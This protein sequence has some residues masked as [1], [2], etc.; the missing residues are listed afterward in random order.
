MNAIYLC[1]IAKPWIDVIHKLEKFYGL[2][3]SYLVI[4]RDEKFEYKNSGFANSYLQTLEEAWKG[5][6]FPL[7]TRKK[8]LDE[9]ELN[10]IA[11][12]ELTALRMMDRLD[13]D[14]Q[15]FSFHARLDYF[16]ELIGYW[17]DVI[18]R[19]DI[20][21]IIS[22]SIPHRVF[23]YALYVASRLRSTRFIMFQMVSF[24]S[25]SILIEDI[26]CMPKLLPGNNF[27]LS[28]NVIERIQ[29][30][31]KDYQTAIPKYEIINKV[32]E[33]KNLNRKLR[34]LKRLLYFY[35]IFT[36]LPNTY[37]VKKGKTPQT[38]QFNWFEFYLTRVKRKQI[39]KNLRKSY[40][41]KLSSP[42]LENK[43]FIFIA[44]HYQPEETSCPS[45]GAY[46]DQALMI[47]LLNDTLPNDVHIFIKEHRTQFYFSSESASGRHLSFYEKVAAISNRVQ[48]LSVE[49][50][51]FKL[52][53]KAIATVTVSGTIG[54]ESA[55]RGTP[56]ILFGRAWYEN[57]P[58]VFKVKTKK[59]LEDAWPHL[60]KLKN[61]NMEYEISIFHKTIESNAIL[62]THYKAYQIYNDVSIQ[63]SVDNIVKGLSDY[64]KLELIEND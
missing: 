45:G 36:T 16:R 13:P 28:S 56:S 5:L 29:N 17:L 15:S 33:N 51:P 60:L 8:V 41:K 4:W 42:I 50:D 21:L 46:A 22:P 25:R 44:L 12:Y 37:W 49:S 55:I 26:D 43:K 59:E 61:K 19:N 2:I 40:S 57:M 6:G 14:G 11:S 63:D 3:P 47:Q 53:D 52:I 32:K 54:W 23:D 27:E 35:K 31:T 48:F 30:V 62:A 18:D 20:Q 34:Q 1:V 38:T 7:G 64:L 58:R 10:T 24:G 39:V 9:L